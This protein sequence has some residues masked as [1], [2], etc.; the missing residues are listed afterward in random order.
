MEPGPEIVG[1]RRHDLLRCAECDGE[2]FAGDV[3]GGA[4]EPAGDDQ[5]IDAGALPADEVDDPLRLV[6]HRGADGD[7]DAERLEPAGEP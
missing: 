1:E 2:G 7:L 4:P 6:R 5:V 3:V